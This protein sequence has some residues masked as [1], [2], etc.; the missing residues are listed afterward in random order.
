MFIGLICVRC[1]SRY[2]VLCKKAEGK[3]KNIQHLMIEWKRLE[4]FLEE[5]DPQLIDDYIP[6]QFLIF[7]KTYALYYG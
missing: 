4:D 7:L 5:K 3:M 2:Y 1:L 6:K